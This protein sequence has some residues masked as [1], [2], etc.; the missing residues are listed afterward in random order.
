MKNP[1]ELHSQARSSLPVQVPSGTQKPGPMS[2][3]LALLILYVVW[4]S[5]YLA[6][7]VSV[8]TFPP[9]LMGSTRFALAGIL[10]LILLQCLR[11][12][13]LTLR[14]C[15]D[16]AIGGF[17]MLLGGNGLVCWAVQE[18]PSGVATLVVAL[19]PLFFVA[20]ESL[21]GAWGAHKQTLEF[22]EPSSLGSTLI[23]HLPKGWTQL[24][25]VVG[26]LG[27]CILVAP[28][29]LEP[30]QAQWNL[31]RISALVWACLCW[32]IGSMYIRHVRDAADPMAGAAVQMLAGAFF[33]LLASYL[34]GEWS[35]F[36]WGQIAPEAWWAWAYLVL[37]GSLVGYT[38]FVWL[39]KHASPTLVSTYGYI[40]P[41]IA[42]FLGWWVLGE[43]VGPRMLIAS[44][45]IIAGVVLISWS[46][47]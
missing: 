7:R 34:L 29:F 35:G 21:L 31:A 13:R 46:K 33:L 32:T 26:F 14:Q 39:M 20:A 19:N 2:I 4:G 47:R 30:S 18:I 11:S 41:M 12:V 28:S 8:Q 38:S 10:L 9:L 6:I 24:G 45:T 15:I 23:A 3:A 5:T 1:V 36:T 17:F 40:N 22:A 43:Q 44:T 27:L 37:A 25:L 16:N 42:V